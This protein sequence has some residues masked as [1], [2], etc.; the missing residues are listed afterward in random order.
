[1]LY[2]NSIEDIEKVFRE[3]QP[4]EVRAVLRHRE[5]AP[6]FLTEE[7]LRALAILRQ[8]DPN[9]FRAPASSPRPSAAQAATP[10]RAARRRRPE[11]P[12]S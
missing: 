3:G 1:M 11:G 5:L 7:G 10:S 6:I 8:R 2:I 4:A 12:L 9:A